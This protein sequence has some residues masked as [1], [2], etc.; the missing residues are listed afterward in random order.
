[1]KNMAIN[2]SFE[3]FY[4][5]LNLLCG[6]NFPSNKDIFVQEKKTV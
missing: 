2:V 1:M 5:S 4:K 6:H 3:H